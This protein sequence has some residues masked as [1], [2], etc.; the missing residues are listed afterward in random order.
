MKWGLFIISILLVNSRVMAI[1]G[2]NQLSNLLYQKNQE[3]LAFE[4]NIESKEA[5][6]NSALS[7]YYPTLNAVGGLG[8]NKT[9]DLTST[10]KGYF[11]YVEGKLNLFRGFKDQSVL[12][13][14]EIDLK[15]SVIQLEAK[16]RELRLQLTEI[17][18]SM[19]LQHKLQTILDEEYKT[20]Q[21][22]KQMAA[23]KVAAGLTGPVDNLEMDLRENEIQ[24]EQR[25]IEQQHQET[26]QK[27]IK[28]IGEEVTDD[29]LEKLDFS[30][31]EILAKIAK[32]FKVEN[33]IEYQKAELMQIHSELEG[34]EIKSDFLPSLDF[35]YELGRLTP[36]EESSLKF[37]ESKYSIQLTIPLFSGFETYHKFK[38]SLLKIQSSE[39]LTIQK[40]NDI[41]S[42][43]NILK[44]K[45]LELGTLFQLNEKRLEN[46]KKYFDLTLAEYK[47]GI[48]NSPDLVSA[49]ERMFS[50][51]KKKYEL[52]KE[53]ETLKVKLE[54]LY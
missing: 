13:Q 25:Q 49:T 3:I 10:Q 2:I 32:P 1:E 9:D 5:L 31:V 41:T 53:L 36:S 37:N 19:I 33:S 54:S 40:K 6:K 21:L 27:F 52:W 30:S 45:I 23:K 44:T 20:T 46:S 48:K 50:A 12:G 26:H 35:K 39:K 4:K 24:I 8:Q 18:S 14:K 22:Q 11:G 16:R 28:I 17:A 29:V 7:E 43:F 34:K 38:S 42:E 47:R 15:L 51:K